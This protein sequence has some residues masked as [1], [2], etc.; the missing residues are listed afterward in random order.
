MTRA[1]LASIGFCIVYAFQIVLQESFVRSSIEPL[2]LNFLTYTL[3][4]GIMTLYFLLFSG[5]SFHIKPNKSLTR[6]FAITT[7]MWLIADFSAVYGLKFSSSLNYSLLTRTMIFVVFLL[8]VFFYKEKFI[9]QKII[10]I[11]LAGIGSVL[12]VLQFDTILTINPGDIFFLITVVTLSVSSIVRK[13]IT[14]SISS[15]QLSYGMF[16]FA[17]II[18]AILTFFFFP[19]TYNVP[20]AAVF[21]NTITG[22]VGFNLVNYAI[23]EGGAV[24]FTLVSNLLPVFTALFSLILLGKFPEIYQLIGGMLIIGSIFL[25]QGV[26]KLKSISP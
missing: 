20:L 15:L 9:W 24:F 1:L 6:L 10:A 11:I 26:I 23:Q 18:Y 7:G 16:F 19:I 22:L 4:A 17:A 21:I 25:F 2:H 12:V 13:D 14:R 3:A 5:K 8:S